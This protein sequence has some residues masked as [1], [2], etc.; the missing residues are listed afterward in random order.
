[1]MNKIKRQFKKRSLVQKFSAA[2][3]I[4]IVL[5]M[6]V[7]NW[8]I[9]NHQR[10]A[11][12]AEMEG[13]HRVVVKN[14]AI[15]A[16][17]PLILMDPLRLDDLVRT[18]RQ[19]PGCV[20]AGVLD[21][22]G[23]IVAH[24]ERKLLGRKMASLASHTDAGGMPKREEYI[25]DIVTEGI[26][27]IYVPVVVGYEL[28]GTVVAGFSREG[29]DEVI[30]TNVGRLKNYIIFVSGLVMIVGI[31]GAF[32]LARLLATPMKKLKERMELVQAGD[33]NVTVP[34][35]YLQNCWE[36]MGC[37]DK[38]C[39]AY[40]EK[41]CW[42]ISNTRCYGCTQG[43]AAEKLCD[44]KKCIVYRESCGDEVGELIEVFNQMIGDLRNNLAALDEAKQE[45]FRLDRLS[46][47]G[48][49]AA[50]VAHEINNP[51]GGISLCFNN[52]MKTKMDEAT[53]QQHIDVINSGFERIQSTVK[54]LLDFSKNSSLST[55]RLSINNVVR[56][57]LKL[58]EYTVTKQGI[59][60][61][62]KL[63]QGNPEVV[64][65]SGKLEQVFLNLMINAV[66]AM[67]GKGVLT[68]KT[69][70]S[71][72]ECLVSISDTGPGIP[73]DILPRIFDPFFTTKG[74]REGTGLGLSVSKALIE[75]HKGQ[76]TV[77]TSEKG[78]AFI[79]HLPVAE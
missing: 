56:S 77:E 78:T 32:L 61:V 2:V 22:G 46:A 33:L 53:R 12:K 19:T 10:S 57:V 29:S 68:V 35:E 13:T 55:S 30:E 73:R 23:R 41:R 72:E 49:I 38:E 43:T 8:L 70:Q 62:E 75:Q 28:V 63:A 52:L 5:M 44:C 15:D 79:V 48:Q 18:T 50:G 4:I 6:L 76:I 74:P 64:A 16:A 36:V 65:D 1:M 67:S 11:L 42:T 39:P 26:K 59:Q 7:I 3:I 9:I 17:E 54:H 21:L 40:G 24:T 71:E 34:N 37:V 25:R 14:L 58:A 69:S 20:Y 31:W 47:I 45:K 51:L 66:Q 60:L 27:E